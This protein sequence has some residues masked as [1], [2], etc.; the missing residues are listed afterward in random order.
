MLSRDILKGCDVST[1]KHYL[2]FLRETGEP[3]HV[4]SGARRRL[5]WPGSSVFRWTGEPRHVRRGARR[6]LEWPGSSVFRWIR[7]VSD[8]VRAARVRS[9]ESACPAIHAIPN[10]NIRRSQPLLQRAKREK[11]SSRCFWTTGTVPAE[12]MEVPAT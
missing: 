12:W 3:R 10:D 6:R 2:S 9:T 11:N 4:R 1:I 8:V 5:E 7:A